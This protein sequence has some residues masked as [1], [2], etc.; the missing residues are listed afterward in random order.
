MPH[1][2]GMTFELIDNP[3]KHITKLNVAYIQYS[4]TEV[5]RPCSS[6][7]VKL[8]ILDTKTNLS[9][10]LNHNLGK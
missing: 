4:T 2:A 5:I 7:K 1:R 10:P 3:D 8:Y 6:P 9:R